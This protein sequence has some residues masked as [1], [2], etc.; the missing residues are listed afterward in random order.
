MVS[1]SKV[2]WLLN[3]RP[4]RSL[5]LT[6]AEVVQK[7]IVVMGM[8]ELCQRRFSLPQQILVVVYYAQMKPM[9]KWTAF[10]T[11]MVLHIFF[12]L[13]HIFCG[14]ISSAKANPRTKRCT[15]DFTDAENM[16]AIQKVNELLNHLVAESISLIGSE[17]PEKYL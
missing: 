2:S 9:T 8:A 3:P 15:Y 12:H 6:T 14:F 11:L 17:G 13:I 16:L 10:F 1:R 7:N 5:H 4:S